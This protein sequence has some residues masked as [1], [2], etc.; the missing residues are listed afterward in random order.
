MS[1]AILKS[2]LAFIFTDFVTAAALVILLLL[3]GLNLQT[4]VSAIVSCLN[5]AGAGV[6]DIGPGRT[7][8]G[9]SAIQ[10]WICAIAMIGGRVEIFALTVVCMPTFWRK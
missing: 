10:K 2:V 7:Y 9:L 5:N 4:A 1:P 3:S 8:G 6:G